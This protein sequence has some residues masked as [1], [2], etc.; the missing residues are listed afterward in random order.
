VV[1]VPGYRSRYPGF[2]SRRCQT[3]WEV[4]DLER[5]PLSLV[6]TIEELLGRNSSGFCLEN[7]EH[8]RGDP[9]RWPRDTLYPQTL[10]L[11]SSKSGGRSVG[12][13]HSRT[14]ATELCVNNA[15]CSLSVYISDWHIAY[16]IS[17]LSRLSVQVL[18]HCNNR[19]FENYVLTYDGRSVYRKAYVLTMTDVHASHR[20]RSPDLCDLRR[21]MAVR[22]L[23]CT[24]AFGIS[25]RWF[26]GYE[27][28]PLLCLHPKTTT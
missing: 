16:T 25:E 20:S 14:K 15:V 12:I 18:A 21:P 24:I 4:V 9:P 17:F 7:R 1:R 22:V 2:D 11:T 6:S 8:S 3:F 5:G 19:H 27:T 13:V 26:W 23:Y 28:L 10:A